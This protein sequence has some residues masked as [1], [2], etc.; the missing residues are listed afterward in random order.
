MSRTFRAAPL[1]PMMLGV[2][3]A[4]LAKVVLAISTATAR[5]TESSCINFVPHDTPSVSLAAASYFPAGA[6]VDISNS[7]SAI[8]A[9]DLPASCRVE[10]VITTNATAGSFANTE[11]WLPDEWNGRML[12]IGNGGFGG[13]VTVSDLGGIA[14]PQGFAGV[15]T[16]TG[17]NSTALDG[18]WAGP[19][20]DNA[21]VD[22]GWR[23]VHLSV[24]AGKAITEQYYRQTVQRSYY[25]GCSTGGRQGLKEI[26]LF[27]ESFDGI[28]VGSP[29]NWMSHLQPW[30]IHMNLDVLPTTSPH[31]MT[32]DMW[33]NV[34]GPEV[35]RQCDALDGLKDGII[36]DPR[37]CS[38]RPETLTC[39]PGQN[40]STCLNADQISALHRIYADY[41][42]ADQ[43]YIFGGYFP[44]GED[45]FFDGLVGSP[46]FA[47]PAD[48]FRFFLLNDTQWTMED[49]NASLIQLGD[50]IDPGQSNAINPNLTAFAAPPHNG[51]VLHYVGWADQL[52]SPGNSLHY[53]ETVHEFTLGNSTLD[54]DDF[55]RLFLVPGM[56]H[57]GGQAANAFGGTSQPPPLSL[58]PEHNILA[59]MVR[60]VEEGVA[61]STIVGVKYN[62]D[63]VANG[64]AF[65]RPLCM[66]PS[67]VTYK[68][69]DPQSA[70]SFE[71][72]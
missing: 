49:Y 23:A 43:T 63:N 41:Y 55:Y 27:P 7:F 44:G 21:I 53:Y 2:A 30:S 40:T 32:Q 18:Q 16:N 60:W 67:T 54:V 24:L 3:L 42:E 62:D 51:K 58:D 64:V 37:R 29:A 48:W 15:S 69:G 11:V 56:N 28:V 45:A 9:S 72:V 34:I 22:W 6:R 12:T 19:H 47:L 65:T 57:W 26:Q 14:I 68:G 10:L 35:M 8:N 46:P 66:Y 17:H 39:R 61:P 71:C 59:A 50:E 38:F 25:I 1:N 13:G 5:G 36:N 4:L 33:V 70:S 52:I 31:F 20:N